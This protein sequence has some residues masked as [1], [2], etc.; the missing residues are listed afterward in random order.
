MNILYI[1]NFDPRLTDF[2]SAQR[3]HLLWESLKQVGNVYTLVSVGPMAPV[4]DDEAERIKSFVFVPRGWLAIR[5][6]AFLARWLSPVEWPFRFSSMKKHLPWKN[7]KFDCIVVR[8]LNGVARSCAW[9]LGDVYV[10]IDDLPIEAYMTITRRKLPWIFR[11]FGGIL[12]SSWQSWLLKKCKGA[13]IASAD[14][15]GHVSPL[16][17]CRALPNL[18]LPPSSEY[19]MFGRQKRQ[20]MTVGLMSYAPNFEGVDWFIDKVWKEVHARHPEF[21]YV[22]CGGGLPGRLREKWSAVPGVKVCGFVRD[23]DAVYEESL[24]VVTPI[25]S[26]SGTCIKVVEAVM[27]GRKVFATPFAIRGIGPSVLSGLQ[28]APTSEPSTMCRAICRF[29]EEENACRRNLQ[30]EIYSTA[31][32]VYSLESFARSVRA[33]LV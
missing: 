9:K 17:G 30:E 22:I 7:V 8:Y 31:K 6:Y 16:C 14:Q 19:K 12:V 24:G 32:S 18:A 4:I 26:G 2:G 28:I 21:S 15:V 10:D 3:T 5:A 20:L 29:L 23:L 27:Y 11:G 13:W 33:V 1:A 25:F